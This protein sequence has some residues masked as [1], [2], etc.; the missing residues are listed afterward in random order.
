MKSKK[1]KHP[2]QP[3]TSDSTTTTTTVGGVTDAG[4]IDV[5]QY[6]TGGGWYDIDEHK[7]QGKDNAIAY[8]EELTAGGE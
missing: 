3:E 7:V 5:S 1:Q 4:V 2:K 8:L 6:H